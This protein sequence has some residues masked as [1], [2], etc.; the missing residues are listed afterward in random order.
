VS[1]TSFIINVNHDDEFE[2]NMFHTLISEM[3]SESGQAGDDRTEVMNTVKVI[4]AYECD[5][6][7]MP[8]DP[9]VLTDV[10]SLDGEDAGQPMEIIKVCPSCLSGKILDDGWGYS[11]AYASP[12]DYE[13]ESYDSETGKPVWRLKPEEA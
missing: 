1:S 7:S 11:S 6:C 12:D 5:E 9:E 13:I 10:M 8:F 2:P 4:T 3:L